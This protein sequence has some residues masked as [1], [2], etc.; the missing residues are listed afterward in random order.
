MIKMTTS[1]R[2]LTVKISKET[3]NV[4]KQEVL[5]KYG[6]TYEVTSLCVEEALSD[7]INKQTK[8]TKGDSK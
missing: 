8:Q 4:F 7:W 6:T 2:Q 1:K 3:V 5:K